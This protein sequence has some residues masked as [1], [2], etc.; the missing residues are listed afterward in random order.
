MINYKKSADK[1]NTY[2]KR[3]NRQITV[4]GL[5]KDNDR[6]NKPKNGTNKEYSI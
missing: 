5:F 3:N 4:R 1:A 2:N 6:K